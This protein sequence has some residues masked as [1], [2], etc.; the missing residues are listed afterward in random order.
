MKLHQYSIK[1]YEFVFYTTLIVGLLWIMIR[2]ID[3]NCLTIPLCL[4]SIVM[5]QIIISKHVILKAW[6][7][8]VAIYCYVV[9]YIELWATKQ[10]LKETYIDKFIKFHMMWIKLASHKSTFFFFYFIIN[11]TT[12]VSLQ[13]GNNP[14][15]C[16]DS[17][18]EDANLRKW[19]NQS[20]IRWC[21]EFCKSNTLIINTKK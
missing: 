14:Y 15:N 6:P 3:M 21:V 4:R 10:I 11:Q 8:L 18:S 16:S 12:L 13:K 7:S 1:R 19:P 2:C 17:I 9:A 5:I 20:V